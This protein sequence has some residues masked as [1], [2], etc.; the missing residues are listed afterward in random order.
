MAPLPHEVRSLGGVNVDTP[1]EEMF[2]DRREVAAFDGYSHCWSH[3]WT[4]VG[5]GVARQKFP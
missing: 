5:A 2:S 4:R 1:G 3:R